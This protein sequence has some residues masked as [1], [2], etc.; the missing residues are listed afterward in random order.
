MNTVTNKAMMKGGYK[1][2]RGDVDDDR[3]LL[4]LALQCAVHIRGRVCTTTIFAVLAR[5]GIQESGFR[6]LPAACERKLRITRN[7]SRYLSI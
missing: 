6:D 3:P 2:L 1:A 4:T 5:A 7:I